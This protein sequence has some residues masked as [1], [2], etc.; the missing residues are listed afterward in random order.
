MKVTDPQPTASDP[1]ADPSLSTDDVDSSQDTDND[2]RS[3]FAQVLAKKREAEESTQ[4]R[5][6]KQTEDALDR[7]AA[8]AL[9]QPQAT[10]EQS[11]QAAPIE[12]K[13]AVGVPVALQ[14]LV[15]EI[16]VATNAAGNQQVHIELNSTALKGLHVVVERKDGA[17][18]IQFQ[19]ASDEVSRLLS[20]NADALSQGLADRGVS[21]A[22]IHVTGPRESASA[23]GNKGRSSSGGSGQRGG[24]GGKR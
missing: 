14:D 13:R 19:S 17:V 21:V 23:Q 4:R 15:R 12:S 22:E 20:R 2:D 1:A 10:F 7:T 16:S 3:A 18:A 9:A 8:A 24:Q 5:S 11:M 6:G